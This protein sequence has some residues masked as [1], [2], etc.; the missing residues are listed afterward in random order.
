[1]ILE[2]LGIFAAAGVLGT[3]VS[4][5]RKVGPNEVLVITGGFLKGPFVQENP[6][7]HSKVKIVKGGGSFVWPIIQQAEIQTLDTFNI[8]AGVEDIKTI[9]MVPVD[10]KANAVLRVGSSPES[11]SIASEK[12]LGLS[13]EQRDMQ[14]TEVVKGGLREVLSELTPEEANKRKDF[15]AAVESSIKDT[16]AKLGLEI[17]NLQITSI[18]DKNGY[19]ESL[20]AP[21]ISAKQAAAQKA[22]AEND[23][24]ARQAKAMNDQTAT[25]AELEASQKI[26][27]KEREVNVVKS[28]YTTDVQ[29]AKAKADKA[30]QLKEADLQAEI[31]RKNIDVERQRLEGTEITK[32]NADKQKAIIEAEGEA[33][34]IKKVADANAE[35]IKVEGAAK[36]EAQEKIA[37]AFNNNSKELL[38]QALIKLLPEIT[39]SYAEALGNVKSM[40]VFD[41]ANG[42]GNQINAGLAQ[43]LQ[44]IKETTGIDLPDVIAKRAEGTTT[45]NEPV[46]V[47]EKKTE[48]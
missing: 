7:T 40:T 42:V 48:E 12:I 34:R 8:E 4:S 32:A 43:S 39:S 47:S 37:Q 17:T 30:Y 21:E 11:I 13:P 33:T 41:G 14:L 35:Q 5:Y 38:A 46:P 18:D 23:K 2:S 44:V 3:G 19:Y 16:F 31:N 24:L 6:E 27:A 1:M 26:A 10:A 22:K 45:L 9:S 20:A 29:T 15:Q 28:E 25:E 36:A